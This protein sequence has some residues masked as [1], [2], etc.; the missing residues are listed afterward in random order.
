MSSKH[1]S[2]VK[3]DGPCLLSVWV[4]VFGPGV[5][6]DGIHKPLWAAHLVLQPVR[7]VL[8]PWH[9]NPW[10][11][12]P[13]NSASN[14]AW[15]EQPLSQLSQELTPKFKAFNTSG[16]S[17]CLTMHRSTVG[18]IPDGIPHHVFMSLVDIL[19]DV[20]KPRWQ[21]ELTVHISTVRFSTIWSHVPKSSID[22]IVISCV[23]NCFFNSTAR[24][25]S[26]KCRLS[27]QPLSLDSLLANGLATG[28][29]HATR[30]YKSHQ[31]ETPEIPG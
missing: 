5:F 28:W 24:Q 9:L 29:W 1:H 19:R 6:S 30:G 15:S 12:S 22:S 25:T 2:D 18:N 31:V 16:Q 10:G 17:I 26:V 11:V 20:R 4:R 13:N 3:K 23:S 14:K 7:N 8:C 21:C 27:L